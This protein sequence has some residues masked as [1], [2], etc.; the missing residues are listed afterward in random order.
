MTRYRRSGSHKTV[1]KNA[2][3][4]WRNLLFNGVPFTGN[5]L[6]NLAVDSLISR[7]RGGDPYAA[8]SLAECVASDLPAPLREKAASYFENHLAWQ[9]AWNSAWQVWMDTRNPIL[10]EVVLKSDHPAAHP[11]DIRAYS[12][13]KLNHLAQA[14]HPGC[15]SGVL[16]ALDDHDPV[17]STRADSV[18][19]SLKNPASIDAVFQA[20]ANSRSIRIAK[21]ISAS[22]Y[23]P[24]NAF[25]F[26][27]VAGIK[28]SHPDWFSLDDP[29]TIQELVDAC[30]DSDPAI[31]ANARH[32]LLCLSS[33]AA[34]DELC[35]IWCQKRSPILQ[36]MIQ[37]AGYIAQTPIAYRV[38]TALLNSHLDIPENISAEDLPLLVNTLDDPLQE[39]AD[40]G[41]EAL[42]HL[43]QVPAQSALVDFALLQ[44]IPVYLDIVQT[45]GYLPNRDEQKALFFFLTYQFSRYDEL[46]FD[47]RLLRAV[48]ETADP[49]IRKKISRIIQTT[50]KTQYLPIFDGNHSHLGSGPASDEEAS[51][52]VKLLVEK[53]DWERLWPYVFELSIFQGI[54]ILARVLESGWRPSSTQDQTVLDSAGFLLQQAFIS[55]PQSIREAIPP[56]ILRTKIRAHG[57]VNCIA[58]SP[59]KPL[60]AIG[61]TSGKIVQWDYQK[62]EIQNI[63]HSSKSVGKVA[64]S[65][66]GSLVSADRSTNDQPSLINQWESG[67]PIQIGSH[68]GP[69]TSLFL[70]DSLCITTG[71]DRRVAVW[72]TQTRKIR[73]EANL[74]HWP[75]SAA[76]SSSSKSLLAL[77]ESFTILTIPGLAATRY[78][79][80]STKSGIRYSVNR[81]AAFSPD[82]ESAFLGQFNG[83]VIQYT[84]LH[85]TMGARRRLVTDQEKEIVAI[86]FIPEHQAFLV[87]DVSGKVHFF[88][89]PELSPEKSIQVP[90]DR[91]SSL[92][93]SPQGDF[94]AVGTGQSEFLFWDL[95]AMT[96]PEI[97]SIPLGKITPRQFENVLGLLEPSLP[98]AH[99]LPQPITNTLNL[100]CILLQ[101]RFQYDIR[102]ED[103]PVLKPG[104]FDIMVEG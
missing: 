32:L 17:I 83:Q 57:R 24:G 36:Q 68:T 77:G 78:Y 94:L 101:H 48:Y 40:A 5:I 43:V 84:H 33:P 39:I 63:Y 3:L 47:M 93:I 28:F 11:A 90:C 70:T 59:L 58:C 75:R 52:I 89:W 27:T 44:E 71:R 100:I 6:R 7:A 14:G 29:K 103:L 26:R 55:D 38:L 8:Q 67:G 72:D 41:K 31:S 85:S 20:W 61:T 51:E 23:V 74:D 12:L 42:L 49:V 69:V 53:K 81:C 4:R 97:F 56:A 15:I 91:L 25:P 86:R 64:F 95:R 66:A 102:I 22:A 60:I 9:P 13:L 18:L 82:G 1:E 21:I 46:D 19:T 62:A 54:Q 88:Q 50:G 30:S 73:E 87:A 104:E 10:E 76:F 16:Q 80:R 37:Q 96:L 98:G 35:G 92:E 79:A 99:E 34:I 2:T 45:A 65:P